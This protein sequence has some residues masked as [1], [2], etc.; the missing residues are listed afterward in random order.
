MKVILILF[1]DKYALWAVDYY[2][3]YAWKFF[4]AK[5]GKLRQPFITVLKKKIRGMVI[6]QHFFDVSMFC[7]NVKYLSICTMHAR[8]EV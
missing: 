2:R 6:S 8:K 5:K 4:L 1:R 7:G 3:P